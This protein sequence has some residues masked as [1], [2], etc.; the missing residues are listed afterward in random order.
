M[1][2][3]L[4]MALNHDYID[5]CDDIVNTFEYRLPPPCSTALF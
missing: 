1:F 3:L 4:T 2:D 5:I